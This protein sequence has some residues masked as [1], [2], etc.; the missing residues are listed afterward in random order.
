MEPNLFSN[1][2]KRTK[3]I[4]IILAVCVVAVSVWIGL[5]VAKKKPTT[6]TTTPTPRP[7]Y[8]PQKNV[9]IKQI[10]T[11]QFPKD[12]SQDLP[13]ESG[14][15]V[16]KNYEATS[17]VD[18]QSTRTYV[19]SMSMEEIEKTYSDYFKVNNWTLYPTFK[20]KNNWGISAKKDTN[21]INVALTP[22]SDGKVLVVITTIQVNLDVKK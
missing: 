16:V 22:R 5:I 7:V 10:D 1:L 9:D 12:L 19:S 13:I 6:S 18:G 15:Q 4:L 11:N 2:Q 21:L 20:A 17:G 14:A 3:V 8:K